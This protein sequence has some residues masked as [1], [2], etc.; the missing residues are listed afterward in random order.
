VILRSYAGIQAVDRTTGKV[1]WE[2]ASEWGLD[3]MARELRYQPYLGAWLSGY[4]VN[5]PHVAVANATLGT[6]STDGTRVYA[7]DDLPLPPFPLS[8]TNTNMGRGRRGPFAEP[9]FGPDLT[10][11]ANPSRLLALD[12]QTG[13]LVWVVGGRGKEGGLNDSY[14]LG[15]PLPLEDG[16]YGVVEKNQE[17]RLVC[18][19]A[20]GGG[21][22]WA[23][24]LAVPSDK[25]LRDVARRIQPLQ[26][27]FED[28]ILVCPTNAGIVL[29]VD[30]FHRNLAWAY[31]YRDENVP[32]DGEPLYW[33]R[34]GRYVI[35]DLPRLREDWKAAVPVIRANKVVLTAPDAPEVVC[36]DLH[37]GALQWKA[38][39][40][41]DDLYVAGVFGNKVLVVGKASCRAL[42]L[43][44]GRPV[45]SVQTGLPSGRGVAAGDVYYLPLKAAPSDKQP[46]V[47]ALDVS[48]GTILTR[49]AA[50]KGEVPGN[51][52]LCG[53]DILSQTAGSL[54]TYSRLKEDDDRDK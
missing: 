39:R 10:N 24:S 12:V 54:T 29:G 32:P 14:F 30:L 15:P 46:A 51:L 20:A 44:D 21:L 38:D 53:E 19:D 11:P 40:K 17:L 25:L 52:V 34:R 4:S 27:R 3:R 41:E 45:W 50:P 2:S 49:A 23:Q 5:N 16:L 35:R 9:D 6:L 48:R 8:T 42:G 26:V 18:L 22:L 37:S 43:A 7:V 33:G 1:A 13:K 47:F 36:L 31:S 28:G